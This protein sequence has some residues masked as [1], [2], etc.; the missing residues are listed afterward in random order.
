MT[1]PSTGLTLPPK[2][3]APAWT[4]LADWVSATGLPV[5]VN[6]FASWLSLPPALETT[7]RRWYFVFAFRPPSWA[8]TGP[9]PGSLIGFGSQ[10]ASEPPWKPSGCP[11]VAVV[12]S[13]EPSPGSTSALPS[14]VICSTSLTASGP[15]KT[16]GSGK[17]PLALPGPPLTVTPPAPI[18]ASARRAAC[19]VAGGAL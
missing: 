14:P 1:G 17:A 3:A 8:M 10:G 7:S 13:G 18:K 5:V 2:V 11:S 15:V 12:T 19:T 9:V 16:T 6:V 4:S